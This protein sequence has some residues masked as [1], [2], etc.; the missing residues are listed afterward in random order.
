MD[1]N[2]DKVDR[3]EDK[4]TTDYDPDPSGGKGSFTL[5][6]VVKVYESLS[7]K[8]L[9]VLQTEYGWEPVSLNITYIGPGDLV[10]I[11]GCTL[12]TEKALNSNNYSLR[13]SCFAV[14]ET[15]LEKLQLIQEHQQALLGR[16]SLKYSFALQVRWG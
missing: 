3:T 7:G 11:P 14:D 16:N 12:M 4:K 9:D 5:V 13:S 2:G 1:G 6:D 8:L 10:Y 15:S